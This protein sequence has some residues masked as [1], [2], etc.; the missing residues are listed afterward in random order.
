MRVAVEETLRLIPGF[1][2]AP[3]PDPG[4]YAAGRLDTVWDA[5]GA[6]A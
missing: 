6:A 4:W 5:P 3:G 1:A 2:L